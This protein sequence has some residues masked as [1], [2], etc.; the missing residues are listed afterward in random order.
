MLLSDRG[1]VIDAAT[2]EYT[3]GATRSLLQPP[4]MTTASHI[5]VT[6]NVTIVTLVQNNATWPSPK[7]MSLQIRSPLGIYWLSL[8]VL[9][10]K[11]PGPSKLSHLSFSW[12]YLS[13]ILMFL[14]LSFY[15]KYSSFMINTVMKA[16]GDKYKKKRRRRTALRLNEQLVIRLVI[17][18]IKWTNFGLN[19]MLQVISLSP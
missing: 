5:P 14:F 7:P 4:L 2:A 1:S 18:T 16:N 8:T 3:C 11:S 12:I 13:S 19:D 6:T 10:P 15:D 17:Q 9:C